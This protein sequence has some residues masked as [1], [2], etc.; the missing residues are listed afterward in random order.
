MSKSLAFE[1]I[2][3]DPR[4]IRSDLRLLERAVRARWEIPHS[5]KRRIL[6]RLREIFDDLKGRTDTNS[7]ERRTMLRV[8]RVHFAMGKVDR[9]DVS[10]A[11]A[12]MLGAT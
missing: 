11:L 12:S 3:S 1:E 10:A 2:L 5:A 4:H 9:E 7:A 8:H 6:E